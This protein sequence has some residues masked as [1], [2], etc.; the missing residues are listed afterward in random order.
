MLRNK[1]GLNQWVYGL[2]KVFAEAELDWCKENADAFQS[3]HKADEF[4]ALHYY[5]IV[6]KKKKNSHSPGDI[7]SLVSFPLS[8]L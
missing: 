3:Q 7:Q 5:N 8:Y 1:N 2:I 4:K 6:P